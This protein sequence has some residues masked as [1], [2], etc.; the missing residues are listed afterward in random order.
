[1]GI[2]HD[3]TR[4]GDVVLEGLGGGVDHDGRE[5][6]VHAGL[7]QLKRIAMV[8]V[9]ADR[10]TGLLDRSFDELDEISAVGVFARTG[11]NL[12]DHR[13]VALLR[14]FGNALNNF[15]IIHIK[16]ADGIAAFVGFFKHF[17]GCY[18]TH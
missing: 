6:V 7:A 4:Q 15:H 9:Q 10:K 12:Q 1:M 11:G 3:L 14:S 2:L 5:A 8:Q 16:S 13:G 17:L 18:N